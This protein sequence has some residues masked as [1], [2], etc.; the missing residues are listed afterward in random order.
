[1]YKYGLGYGYNRYIFCGK[2]KDP[3]FDAN[4]KGYFDDKIKVSW[5][6]KLFGK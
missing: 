2:K 6:Q 5:W 1:M 4:K 3:Y